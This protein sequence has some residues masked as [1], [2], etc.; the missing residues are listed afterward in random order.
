MGSDN[1]GKDKRRRDPFDIFGFNDRFFDE[2]FNDP[3]MDDFR[4]MAE[5]M[6][7]IL[8]NAKPGKSYVHGYSLR[9][10][11]DGKPHLEEFGN[12]RV[13]S[14]EGKSIISED[15]EPLTDVIE[16]K[17]E[18]SVTVEIPGVEKDDID[19]S[20]TEHQ[21]EITV[22]TA[23]HKYHKKIELPVDVKPNTTKAT[24]KN[25]ILD[26]VIK[27]MNRQKKDTKGFRVNIN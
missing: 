26:V 16:G 21:L 2:F 3:V 8:S 15:R 9:I 24:Y 10:G 23:Q 19:L 22:N 18:V 25:G 4:R 20:V 13:K 27:R 6:M 11:P 17:E 7:R 1:K 14:S 12:H 5:E